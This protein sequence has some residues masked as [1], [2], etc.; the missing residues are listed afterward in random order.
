MYV[1]CTTMS[2]RK[3]KKSKRGVGTRVESLV[4][5]DLPSHKH[6]RR[7]G[8]LGAGLSSRGSRMCK[9]PGQNCPWDVQE[10]T[11]G[12]KAGMSQGLGTF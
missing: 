8:G 10:A 6:E 3:I 4:V 1:S 12:A 7:T 11:C 5:E 9:H 2:R